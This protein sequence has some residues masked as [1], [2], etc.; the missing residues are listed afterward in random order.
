LIAEYDGI[1][2]ICLR[3]ILNLRYVNLVVDLSI[4]TTFLSKPGKV[5]GIGI[6]D[7]KNR[8]SSVQP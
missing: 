6:S 4:G 8:I 2:G 7:L 1:T 3:T 5:S